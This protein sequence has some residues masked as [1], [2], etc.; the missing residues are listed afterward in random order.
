M[1]ITKFGAR[2][3]Q[4][5]ERKNLTQQN[6]AEMLGVTSATVIS[7]ERGGKCPSVDTALAIAEKFGVSLD[8]LCG[9]ESVEHLK[10]STYADILRG[11]VTATWYGVGKIKY[12]ENG[13]HICFYDAFTQ[14][15]IQ[16]WQRV[17]TA[18]DNHHIDDDLYSLWLNREFETLSK[19]EV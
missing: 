7:W 3:K 10:P 11:L 6:F 18:C 4:L 12:D 2:V 9:R 16:N 19:S 13:T 17:K 15:I 8:W 1:D 14:K 5:R